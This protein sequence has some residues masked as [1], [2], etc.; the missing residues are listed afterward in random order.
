MDDNMKEEKGVYP[1]RRLQEVSGNPGEN[2]KPTICKKAVKWTYPSKR[3][4]NVK[5]NRE[6]T[7]KLRKDMNIRKV[8]YF[9]EN[10]ISEQIL[11]KKKS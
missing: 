1:T 9:A 4:H 6:D 8:I 5:D 3:F 2:T 7:I 11:L 10:C